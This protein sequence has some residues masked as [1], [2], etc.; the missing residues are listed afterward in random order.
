MCV[1]AAQQS[2]GLQSPGPSPCQPQPIRRRP[3]PAAAHPVA[4]P[5]S[6]QRTALPRPHSSSSCWTCWRGACS[7]STAARC[8]S[9]RSSSTCSCAGRDWCCP[10][11]RW[12]APPAA[13]AVHQRAVTR[14]QPQWLR[15]W[16]RC[17]TRPR[18]W[19]RGSASQRRMARQQSST[20]RQ[21][22]CWG[23]RCCSWPASPC[24]CRGPCRPRKRRWQRQARHSPP[25]AAQLLPA[26]AAAYR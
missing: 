23:P 18:A 20:K 11:C 14:A 8:T 17:L 24:S 19:R 10:L 7:A 4:P 6:R 1:Y 22:A 25:A 9:W 3:L 16:P 21:G 12:E 5:A 15:Q 13:A 26:W 2:R